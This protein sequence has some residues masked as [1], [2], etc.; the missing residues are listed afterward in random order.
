MNS[1]YH[2]PT[3]LIHH[4]SRSIPADGSLQFFFRFPI[5]YCVALPALRSHEVFLARLMSAPFLRLSAPQ[6]HL[7]THPSITIGQFQPI[8]RICNLVSRLRGCFSTCY[9]S[10]VGRNIPFLEPRTQRLQGL[11][12]T[13]GGTFHSQ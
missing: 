2:Y 13:G 4:T 1:F 9:S 11:K 6:I 10:P 8:L 3:N 7:V 12:R 5:R